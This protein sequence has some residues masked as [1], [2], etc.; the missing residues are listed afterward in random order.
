MIASGLNLLCRFPTLP[1][2]FFTG[3]IVLVHCY[4]NNW[5]VTCY[6]A[7]GIIKE[8]PWSVLLTRQFPSP[9]QWTHH[10]SLL[11]CFGSRF[12]I[13]STFSIKAIS[14]IPI[15]MKMPIL[16]NIGILLKIIKKIDKIWKWFLKISY[17]YQIF[18]Q[19]SGHFL[20][21]LAFFEQNMN[22]RF[23]M[24]LCLDS[25]LNICENQPRK[26]HGSCLESVVRL[27][28]GVLYMAERC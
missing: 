24:K 20:C 5:V 7:A 17:L 28:D 13:E 26:L 22:V 25:L 8:F 11:K 12:H 18:E 3:V 19:N 16:D 23:S 9:P 15:A 14:I 4:L 1:F 2:L 27:F 6:H 10:P 21:I